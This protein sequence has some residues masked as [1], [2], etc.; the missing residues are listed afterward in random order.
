MLG[1]QERGCDL[2]AQAL[3][4]K[5]RDAAVAEGVLEPEVAGLVAGA[6]DGERVG[7]GAQLAQRIDHQRHIGAD[8]GAHAE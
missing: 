1:N 3:V 6:A 8:R 2:L 7:E 5:R 4:A